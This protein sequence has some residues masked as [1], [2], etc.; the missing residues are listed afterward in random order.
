MERIRIFWKNRESCL[1]PKGVDESSDRVFEA[2]SS[3]KSIVMT[4]DYMDKNKQELEDLVVQT[5]DKMDLNPIEFIKVGNV[6]R[7]NKL[8]DVLDGCYETCVQ[9]L[10]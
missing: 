3:V 8:Q 9:K 10:R 5:E 2:A 7:M 4:S 6:E 1:F